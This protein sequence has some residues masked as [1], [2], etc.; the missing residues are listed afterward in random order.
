MAGFAIQ[1]QYIL[2]KPDVWVGF[3]ETGHPTKPGYL[4]TMFLEN[5][6]S[7]ETVECR[8]NNDEVYIA[9]RDYNN[10]LLKGIRGP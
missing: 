7:R 9:I 5:F 3:D 10:I 4:E 6:A 2:S 1:V 8:G